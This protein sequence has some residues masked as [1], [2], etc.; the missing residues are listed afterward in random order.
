MVLTDLDLRKEKSFESGQIYTVLSR[1]KTYD[2]LYYIGIFKISTVK[3]NKDALLE[4]EHLKE[5]DIFSTIK[6]NTVIRR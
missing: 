1:A 6:R 2:N 5:N 3:V 4:Y